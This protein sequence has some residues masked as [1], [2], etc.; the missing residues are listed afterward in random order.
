MTG[1]ALGCEKSKDQDADNSVLMICDLNGI[2]GFE[3]AERVDG[4][5]MPESPSIQ[6]QEDPF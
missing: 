2:W 5:L 6:I 1:I 4:P 3:R